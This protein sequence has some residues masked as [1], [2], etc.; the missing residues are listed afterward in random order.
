M[1]PGAASI[2]L[3]FVLFLFAAA[4]AVPFIL[5]GVVDTPTQLGLG[6]GFVLLGALFV[7]LTLIAQ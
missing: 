6:V 2:G 5:G 7:W 3:F 4:L 1:D